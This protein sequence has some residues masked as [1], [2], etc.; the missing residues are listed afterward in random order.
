MRATAAHDSTNWFPA[1]TAAKL[2]DLSLAM[3][4]YLCRQ[5]IVEPTC[6][7]ARGHGAR[8]HYSFGDVVAL[9]LV[10]RLSKAGVSVL[11]LKRAM[12][13]LRKFHPRIT[14]TSLPGSHVVTD[15]NELFLRREGEVIERI[16][17][18]QFAFVFVIELSQIQNDVARK[19]RA[20][21]PRLVARKRGAT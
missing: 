14:L 17:D 8:R 3:V 13:G 6:N 11:R 2:A 15:G 7:C 21:S 20:T 1:A 4:N 19:L 5:G 16:F 12:C 10:A 18:G 9:R